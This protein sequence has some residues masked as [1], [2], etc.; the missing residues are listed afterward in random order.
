MPVPRRGMAYETENRTPLVRTK[1]ANLQCPIC[2]IHFHRP[3]SHADRVNVNYCSRACANEG[4]RVRVEVECCSCARPMW[5][6]PSWVG[7][8]RACSPKC[9]TLRKVSAGKKT[10][11]WNLK[12]A[13][14]LTKRIWEKGVCDSCGVTHGP[15]A[16]SG[17]AIA[18]L[19][20]VPVPDDSGAILLCQR[21]RLIRDGEKG[22]ETLRQLRQ[23]GA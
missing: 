21:C 8:V 12:G 20:G 11:W 19:D 3:P 4:K 6:I 16:V 9:T 5:I 23:E 18:Y 1:N 2:L 10:Y 17:M 15:W 22:R 13:L 7:K 14:E